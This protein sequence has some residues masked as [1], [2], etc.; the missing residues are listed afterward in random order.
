MLHGSNHCRVWMNKKEFQKCYSVF[1]SCFMYCRRYKNANLLKETTA[2]KCIKGQPTNTSTMSTRK[3]SSKGYCFNQLMKQKPQPHDRLHMWPR[4]DLFVKQNIEYSLNTYN[5]NNTN[6]IMWVWFC[7]AL[8]FTGVIG[9]FWFV[10]L[11]CTT[12]N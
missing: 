5:F 4:F 3:S 6:I 10:L 9:L 2:Y 11:V 1:L 12:N 8:Y 7:I